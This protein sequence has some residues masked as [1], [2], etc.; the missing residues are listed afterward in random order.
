M[1][2]FDWQ[3][4]KEWI[5]FSEPED[6]FLSDN[7]ENDTLFEAKIYEIEKWKQNIVFQ[8]V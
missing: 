1:I 7:F 2:I 4:I 6:I 8:P 3:T 5:F